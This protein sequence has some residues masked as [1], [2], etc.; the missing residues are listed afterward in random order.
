MAASKSDSQAAKKGKKKGKKNLAVVVPGACC[1]AAH[2]SSHVGREAASLIFHATRHPP[3][4]GPNVRDH[5]FF[6]RAQA[7]RKLS[8]P[9]WQWKRQVFP[10]AIR[11]TGT[12]SISTSR[13]LSRH[14]RAARLRAARQKRGPDLQ[15]PARKPSKKIRSL[16]S[17]ARRRKA[18]RRKGH[19][20]ALQS[21]CP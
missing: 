8:Q 9:A 7:A 19:P 14:L 17:Q 1:C 2:I 10:T 21:R 20:A 5:Q 4:A 18:R 16:R 6:S 13:A 11:C 12:L 3:H 15:R